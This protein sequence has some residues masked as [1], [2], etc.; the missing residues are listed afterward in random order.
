VAVD[1][2]RTGVD[3]LGS[4]WL[5]AVRDRLAKPAGNLASDERRMTIAFEII[6]ER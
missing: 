6:A 4:A 5:S 3:L 1:G 2:G